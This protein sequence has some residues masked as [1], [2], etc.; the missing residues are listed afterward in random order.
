MI[1]R[2]VNQTNAES[3]KSEAEVAKA[4]ADAAL[5]QAQYE[6]IIEKRKQGSS[7]EQFQ[8]FIMEQL[9]Q[10]QEQ[11]G[12]AREAINQQNMAMLQERMAMLQAELDSMRQAPREQVSPITALQ[13][14]IDTYQQIRGIFVPEGSE[15]PTEEPPAS[16]MVQAWLEKAKLEHEYKTLMHTD[17]HAEK[18]EGLKVEREVR[19]KEVEVK[20]RMADQ[21]TRGVT[22]TLPKVVDLLKQVLGRL[23]PEDASQVQPATAAAQTTSVPAEVRP[24]STITLPPG[25]VAD[26]CPSCGVTILYREEWPGVICQNC[27]RELSITVTH[28]QNGHTPVGANEPAGVETEE[29]Q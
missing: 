3:A 12:Q 4:K 23:G 20:E 15:K 18:M 1:A 21:I 28:N 19:L 17:E 11:L 10:T 14:S 22:D 5:A 26:A 24:S 7:N 6:E 8:Q 25:V 29:E 16:P 2:T 13:Q 9:Q 27:G